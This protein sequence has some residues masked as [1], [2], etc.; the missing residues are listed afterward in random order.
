[1]YPALYKCGLKE[2][3]AYKVAQQL[4]LDK[5]RDLHGML[6]MYVDDYYG[7]TTRFLQSSTCYSS[8][9]THCHL[10]TIGI[11]AEFHEM[12]AELGF[13]PEVIAKATYAD[14]V[15]PHGLA[16]SWVERFTRSMY[17]LPS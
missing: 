1:M 13:R 3:V 6:S 2:D 5:Y 15:L 11:G 14:E 10:T 17:T 9:S 7:N 12:L 8:L 16:E 4:P